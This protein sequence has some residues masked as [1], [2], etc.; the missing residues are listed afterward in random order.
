[1]A[2][3]YTNKGE[4]ILVDAEDLLD[5][6]QYSWSINASGYAVRGYHTDG[7]QCNEIMHRRLMALVRGDKL[8]VDH[9]DGNRLNN[10]K[11]NLRVCTHIENSRN[12]KTQGNNSGYKGVYWRASTHRWHANI[13]HLG[14]TYFLGSYDTAEE[15]HRAYCAAAATLHADFANAGDGPIDPDRLRSLLL[16]PAKR[17]TTAHPKADDSPLAIPVICVETGRRFG[18]ARSAMLWL[19][20]NGK[21]KADASP[22]TAVCRGRAKSAYGLAWRYDEEKIA[23]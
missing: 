21:L 5:L 20:E 9:I 1:M 2:I 22:I 11:S 13:G 10:Q 23:A 18:S 8:Q 16:S 14:K 6:R 17:M 15:A 4:E 3:L 7:R 12:R 19:R